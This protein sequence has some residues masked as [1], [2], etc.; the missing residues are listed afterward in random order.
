VDGIDQAKFRVPRDNQKTHALDCLIRPALHVQGC[1]AHG[2]GFHFAIADADLKKDTTT[3][4]EVIARM[5]ESIYIKHGALPR[6]LA[7]IQDNTC[8]ECKNQLIL[9]VMVKKVVLLI[10]RHIW[11]GFPNKGHS[12]GPLDAVYGQATV[13]LGNSEFQDDKEVE[14]HLQGFLTD[15][16][17]EPGTSTNSLAY[18][19][20]QAAEWVKWGEDGLDFICS[21][22]TGPKA[23]HSFHIC[24]RE[25]L[26]TDE[27]P[28]EQTAWDG[29]PRPRGGDVVVALRS[30]MADKK[31]FQVALLVPQDTV[32]SLRLHAPVQPWGIHDR[33]PFNLKDRQKTVR[34]ATACHKVGALSDKAWLYLTSWAMG[35]LRQHKRPKQYTFLQQRLTDL[36]EE[37]LPLVGPAADHLRP[38]WEETPRPVIILGAPSGDLA[39]E[40]PEDEGDAELGI[41]GDA[42]NVFD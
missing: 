19:L 23:P 4:L 10:H 20:D 2:F 18:K 28:G 8:R 27:L 24:Y 16:S 32:Q 41:F 29:A 9:K 36:A 17:L 11:L 1:W 31:A 25:D 6:S 12:H 38:T 35:T 22:L 42:G 34:T 21:N 39:P 13:K 33:R 30:N 14:Q 3:N 15:G 7:I 26:S 40:P 37:A 5:S